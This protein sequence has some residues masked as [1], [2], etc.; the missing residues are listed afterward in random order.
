MNTEQV[1]QLVGNKFFS[2][3]FLKKNNEVRHMHCR[4]G[5]KRHL[6]GGEKRYDTEYY[7]YL[8]VY[9]M[10]KKAYRTLNVNKLI[11]LKVN[12]EVIKVDGNQWLKFFKVKQK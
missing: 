12:K 9:D 7:N 10:Q 8:I 4:L 11:E 3:T 5:V 2:A 1:K 6:K